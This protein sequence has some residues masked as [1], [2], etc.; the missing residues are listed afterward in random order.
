MDDG[1]CTH[2]A[3]HV[4]DRVEALANMLLCRDNQTLCV[5]GQR[6]LQRPES[7]E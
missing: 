3:D 5:C 4:K 7:S 2:L 6:E 1:D